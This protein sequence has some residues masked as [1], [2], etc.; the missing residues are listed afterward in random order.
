[1]SSFLRT[2]QSGISNDLSASIRPELFSPDDQARYGINSQISCF[3]YDPV[4]SLLAIG[5]NESKFG[6]GKIYV[7]GQGRV[8]KVL[9]PPRSTSL[10]F[11]QFTANKLVSLDR[12]NEVSVWDLDSGSRIASQVIAGQ[13][14][15]L[16]TD[17][18][19]DWAFIGLQ[20]GDVVS[21]DLDRNSLSRAFR[22]P[23]FW[24]ER[25]PSSRAATLVCMAMHPRDIGK[26]LLGYT[27]GAVIYSFKQN[28]AVHFFEYTLPPGAPG[29]SSISVDTWRRPRLTHALWHPSGTFIVTAHEDGSLVLWDPKEAK[30]ITARTLRNLS[31]EKPTPT[32]AN[33]T[34]SE[35]FG[36]VEWCC[37]DNCDDTGLL[38]SGGEE[39]GTSSRNLTFLELGLTP[40]YATSSWQVLAE[41]FRGKRQITLS[42]PP[43][44]QAVDFI[45]IPRSSPH[46]AGAQDPVAI[47]TLLSSG[48]LITMSFP[49]G[50]PISPTN[51]LHPSIF[52]VHPFVTKFNVSSL[53]RPRWLSMMEKRSQ[54]E[55]LLKGGAQGPRPRKRFEERTIIQAAHGDGTIRIWDSGHADEI[56][57]SMQL[58]VDVARALDRYDDIDV[59]AMSLAGNTGEFVVG[60][61]TGEAIVFRWGANRFYGRDQ[62]QRL[63]PNPKGL[64]DIS[65]RAE[66][67]LKEGL[68]PFVLYEMM[69]GAVTA[70]QV[71][72]VG[73]VAVGS[74]LGFLT[75]ID[76]R[77]PRVFYQAPMTDFS[78]Q[79]KRSSFFKRDHHHASNDA[80]KKEW[81]VVIEFGVLTLD[82]DKYS[83]ICCFVGTNLG[84]VM[85]FKLLPSGDG[86]YS[87]QLAGVVAF[88]GPIV[89][90]SPI[91]INTG[92]PAVA[93][94]AIVASLR[95]GKQIHGALV[96]VTQSEIRVFKPANSKGACREFDDVLCDAASVAELE[97]QG[98][99][100]V[101]ILGDRT[102]RAY[103]LP[104]LKE[105]GKANLPMIDS[106]RITSAVVTPTGDV[107]AWTGP[108]ELAVIH[109]WGTGKALQQSPD[110][111]VNPKL[112][113]PPRP[114]ISNLQWISG[115]QYVSPLDLDLLV[116][117]PDRPASK[118]MLE[119]AAA[120]RRAA[121][122]GTA[123]VAAAAGSS[124]ES[125]GQYLSRQLTERTEKLNIMSDGMDNL[126]QQSQGWADD[127]NKFMGKQK[128]NL[129]MGSIKRKFF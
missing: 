127:V 39:L 60:T 35:P 115:T 4:Q 106:S 85:T 65:S 25:G 98:F 49:S 43:G 114:T 117:G 54:G 29:G 40:V 24:R 78:K 83:S 96:A 52:F 64:T 1:M 37:K 128:R 71:S 8:Q 19:L 22:L 99:A 79:D 62:P 59:S 92:K 70:V 95:E 33:P 61:R 126:Q 93:T 14:V 109:V 81:P 80:P 2:K 56:E 28:K 120:E 103:S 58:Q 91:E 38:V 69:Q 13:V 46:F 57:N 100:V 94:G 107:F 34:S 41:Y 88:E 16:V 20:S 68:Q 47:I 84:K 122:G 23:N 87:A 89:S 108:S 31:V 55:P 86:A 82:E 124:Q 113:S 123:T 26:L 45:L 121:A 101:A 42:L 30:L 36:N 50:Y 104:A 53:E 17:P 129:V 119:A 5:T 74:E 21:Y 72:N 3:G 48:E 10:L 102:A 51:Q 125:W 9:D 67:T 105:I 27:H 18:M 97:L 75:L 76:L 111:M 12:N 6:P 32:T 110:T 44:A 118:R 90:L 77:G 112:E 63:D 73:F 66:S 116:G 11:L 7:F 15:S